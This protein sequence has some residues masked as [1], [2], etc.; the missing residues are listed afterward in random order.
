MT[1]HRSNH[2]NTTP[3]DPA[4]LRRALRLVHCLQKERGASCAYYASHQKPS[5]V[6]NME[7]ARKDCDR[8]IQIMIKNSKS[9]ESK[10]QSTLLKIRNMVTAHPGEH[11]QN[12]RHKIL[13]CFNALISS[14][15][16]DYFMEKIALQ[17]KHLFRKKRG[18]SNGNDNNNNDNNQHQD[19]NG[20]FNYK[21]RSIS[22]GNCAAY[23]FQNGYDTTATTANNHYISINMSS[24]PSKESY[25]PDNNREIPWSSPPDTLDAIGSGVPVIPDHV[26]IQVHGNSKPLSSSFGALDG[27]GGHRNYGGGSMH[28]HST[29]RQQTT[30]FL[31]SN[32]IEDDPESQVAR[33]LNLL[34][35]FV[36]L[37]ESTGVERAVLSSLVVSGKE[38]SLLLSDL[39]LEVE[40]QRRLLE[41]LK[42]L[43]VG[44][45]TSLVE[46]LVEMSKPLRDLQQ[47]ILKNFNLEGVSEGVLSNKTVIWELMTVYINKLHALELLIIE[48]IEYCLP[49][50]TIDNE[51]V[52]ENQPLSG[53]NFI[54][55]MFGSKVSGEEAKA[56]LEQMPAEE[57]KQM[58]L[59]GFVTSKNGESSD[60]DTNE[61]NHDN[62]IA[63]VNGE[64]EDPL[65]LIPNLPASKE[66]EISLY[67]LKFLKRIGKGA[68]GTTYV[69]NWT[70]L[71]VAV[72]VASITETGLEGWRTEV[73]ALQKLHHPNVI[74]LLGSVYHPNPLTFCLV[75]EHCS[76]GDLA[77]AMKFPT[78]PGFFFKVATGISHGMAYLHSRG[79]MHRGMLLLLVFDSLFSF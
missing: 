74:R 49:E 16:H 36:K 15:V 37:K 73:Q 52:S 34:A 55:G 46:E 30:R 28:H 68:A 57:I 60:T 1:K 24:A 21:M 69:A 2:H 66:W 29:L 63:T 35:C 13:V 33:L 48:E 50:I 4:L 23:G 59:S 32:T 41:E 64:I 40:N 44:S 71:K 62:S 18:Q 43:P 5:I 42:R 14:V 72:K 10:V 6:E 76:A 45:L 26:P 27:G 53:T 77:H 22:M 17:Q 39:V 65:L 19:A 8:A 56:R 47:R 67:E 51:Q 9:S 75:L 31:L 78:A 79:I 20:G 25:V 54:T 58:L 11:T 12:S 61:S 3:V 70:G 7:R 38:D